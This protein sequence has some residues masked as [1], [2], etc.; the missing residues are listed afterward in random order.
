MDGDMVFY[1]LLLTLHLFY[2]YTCKSG[3][4]I[5]KNI[6]P[7]TKGGVLIIILKIFYAFCILSNM[8]Y[9][10]SLYQKGPIRFAIFVRK[11]KVL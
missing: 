8:L 4:L 2:F 11:F 3:V 10:L 5:M 6:V 1:F 7:V 9:I